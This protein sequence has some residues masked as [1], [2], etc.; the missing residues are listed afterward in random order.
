M[1]FVPFLFK[2]LT[3]MHAQGLVQE[4]LGYLS[5]V[6]AC[7]VIMLSLTGWLPGSP[8]YFWFFEHSP[9]RPTAV[10]LSSLC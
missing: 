6:S 5:C 3:I 2:L 8:V 4:G 9:C 1:I 7:L 10:G